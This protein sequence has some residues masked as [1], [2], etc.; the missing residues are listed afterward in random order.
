MK[1]H[2]VILTFIIGAVILT[3][4]VSAAYYNTKSFSSEEDAVLFSR[5]QDGITVFD[6]KIYYSDIEKTY[7]SAKRY[8]PAEAYSTAPYIVSPPEWLTYIMYK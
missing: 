6:Y 5:S 2:P 4:G 7:N 8:V 3:A 1:K